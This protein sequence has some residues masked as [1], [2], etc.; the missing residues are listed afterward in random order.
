LVAIKSGPNWGNSSQQARLQDNFK[1]AITVVRQSQHAAQ[2]QA[3][4]G[5]CYGK[6]PGC[7]DKGLYLLMTGQRFW[8]FLSGDEDLYLDIIDPVGY[9]A[10]QHNDDFERS[11]SAIQ[12]RLTSEF[13]K[14][15]CD[16]EFCINWN[17]LV[18]F[19]SG[20][21]TQGSLG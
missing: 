2:V 10:R 8:H 12:N 1:R 13:I 20:N 7:K 16:E 4:L 18:A 17:R 9:Q 14:Q 5:I 21:I 3:V 15:F 19:N 11:R 6:R